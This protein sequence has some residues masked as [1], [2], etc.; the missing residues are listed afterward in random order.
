MRVTQNKLKKGTAELAVP[1]SFN[2]SL[3]CQV[4]AKIGR[5]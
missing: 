4:V 5:P 3:F 1:F 2:V